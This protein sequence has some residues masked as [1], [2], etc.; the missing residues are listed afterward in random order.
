MSEVEIAYRFRVRRRTAASW[1]SLNEPLLDSEIG[2][3]SDT[4]WPNG[5]GRKFKIGPGAWNSLPYAVPDT[6]NAGGLVL[7]GTATVTGSAATTLTLSGLD[8]ATDKCYRVLF[9][10]KNATASAS[11][12]NLYYSGDTTS[13]NY[14]RQTIQFN[15]TTV[16][17]AR[18][19]NGFGFSMVASG[20]ATGDMEILLDFDGRARAFIRNSLSTAST[21]QIH[22]VRH[23][24]N[25]VGNVTSITFSASVANSL[26]VGSYFKV[27]KVN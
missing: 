21:I 3:E 1:A 11:N 4:V 18:N 25:V 17:G 5:G 15:D 14:Y 16:T 2:L 13:G 19:N 26:A 22:D 20:P 12:V 27:Y 24:R 10:C 8:L 9:A 7:V 23:V 6:P